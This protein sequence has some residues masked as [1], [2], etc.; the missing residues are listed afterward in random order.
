LEPGRRKGAPEGGKRSLKIINFVDFSSTRI[1]HAYAGDCPAGWNGAI[2]RE[3]I[4][5]KGY[6]I[7][8]CGIVQNEI[9][10]VGSALNRRT[11]QNLIERQIGNIIIEIEISY[12]D[13][14]F[15]HFRAFGM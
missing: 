13:P 1:A 4:A 12:G 8:I 2:V 5:M 6:A 9:A 10:A 14:F 15:A 3:I 7:A 11:D